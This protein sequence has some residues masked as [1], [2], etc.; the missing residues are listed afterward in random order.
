MTRSLHLLGNRWIATLLLAGVG[1][2]TAAPD[3]PA[4]E[5]RNGETAT[6]KTT[7]QDVSFK[8]K[9]CEPPWGPDPYRPETGPTEAWTSSVTARM[10]HDLRANTL[11]AWLEAEGGR[12]CEEGCASLERP[13]TGEAEVLEPR[14]SVREARAVGRCDDRL[15]AWSVDVTVS[16]AIACSC[17]G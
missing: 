2:D 8:W 11:A 5:L 6:F 14:A 4:L 10:D 9:G 16:G 7:N 15:T 3:E 17:G 12:A 1:C 13:W